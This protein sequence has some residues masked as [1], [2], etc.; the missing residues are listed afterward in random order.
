[1]MCSICLSRE[2]VASSCP[3]RRRRADRLAYAIILVASVAALAGVWTHLN[4]AA[5]AVALFARP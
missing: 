1:M 5:H 3:M 2:H 4:Q